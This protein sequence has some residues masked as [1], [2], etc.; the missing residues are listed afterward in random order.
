M[1]YSARTKLG[2]VMSQTTDLM[3]WGEGTLSAREAGDDGIV[4]RAVFESPLEE[5]LAHVLEGATPLGV[6]PRFWKAHDL[7]ELR[8]DLAERHHDLLRSRVL[9]NPQLQIGRFRL[10][11]ACIVA[12]ATDP[13]QSQVLSPWTI[14][15]I[16]AD[17][18]AYHQGEARARDYERDRELHRNF[19]CL[20]LRFSGRE[21]HGKPQ[22]I[23]QIVE[24][25]VEAIVELDDCIA[26]HDQALDEDGLEGRWIRQRRNEI[27]WQMRCWSIDK[28][29]DD[30]LHW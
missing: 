24:E 21:I 15:G 10:D 30:A 11:C 2:K 18:A 28:W 12:T 25:V 16:E 1:A 14:F 29:S 8:R 4:G 26:V 27:G 7:D 3:S 19:G 6:R 20:M 9:L 5:R 17:G 23:M 22:R 13:L